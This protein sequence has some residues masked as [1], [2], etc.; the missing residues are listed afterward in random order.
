ML[1]D[2]NVPAQARLP[3]QAR[4]PAERPGCTGAPAVPAG[5]AGQPVRFR[6]LETADPYKEEGQLLPPNPS[7]ALLV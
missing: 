6:P 7:K 2:R 3:L 1:P 4:T 5:G